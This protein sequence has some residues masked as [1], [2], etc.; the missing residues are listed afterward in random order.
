MEQMK[1][2]DLARVDINYEDDSLPKVV[3]EL[4]PVVF[5][6]ATHYC[7]LLGPDKQLG[8]DGCGTSVVEAIADWEQDLQKRLQTSDEN[9]EV[10][11]YVKDSLNASNK[12]VW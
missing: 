10:A 8:I 12:K 7:C 11:Q 6:E 9:D 4:R 5:A 1:I 3:K 2:D